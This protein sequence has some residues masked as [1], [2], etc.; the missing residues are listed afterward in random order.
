MRWPDSRRTLPFNSNPP[1]PGRPSNEAEPGMIRKMSICISTDVREGR[2]RT[3]Q[4]L[5]PTTGDL[6]LLLGT[7]GVEPN[8]SINADIQSITMSLVP[9]L[10]I[11]IRPTIENFDHDCILASE[12]HIFHQVGDEAQF[13]GFPRPKCFR[14][15]SSHETIHAAKFENRPRDFSSGRILHDDVADRINIIFWRPS[16]VVGKSIRMLRQVANVNLDHDR[17]QRPKFFSIDRGDEF[18]WCRVGNFLGL[19][20]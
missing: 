2:V 15:T 8:R 7:L 20:D 19:S 12:C 10:L 4:A 11:G 17:F 16:A 13:E 6:G 1:R 3:P 18:Q 5:I 14:L 9:L